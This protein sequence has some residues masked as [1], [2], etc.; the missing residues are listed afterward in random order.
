MKWVPGFCQS[1]SPSLSLL[2]KPYRSSSFG[3][4]EVMAVNFSVNVS[5]VNLTLRASI[6]LAKF[7]P[8]PF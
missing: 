6:S 2:S 3:N 1:C 8:V 5:C 4:P 7:F